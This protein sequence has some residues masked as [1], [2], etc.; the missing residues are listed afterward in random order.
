VTDYHSQRQ[1]LAHGQ[2][3]AG[4]P[5]F[6]GARLERAAESNIPRLNR[7]RPL[8]GCE[9]PRAI[10]RNAHRRS[11]RSPA[12][13]LFPPVGPQTSRPSQCR[14]HARAP[15]PP[16]PPVQRL[17]N[18]TF[19]HFLALL[20]GSPEAYLFLRKRVSSMMAA[21]R[22]HFLALCPRAATKRAGLHL[23]AGVCFEPAQHRS[24]HKDDRGAFDRAKQ[25]GSR[26]RLS[27]ANCAAYPYYNI[28]RF[29]KIINAPMA[30][31]RRI[32]IGNIAR[33]RH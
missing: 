28:R 23:I 24:G 21:F 3:V 22:C 26:L 13:G 20:A 29:T 14:N 9:R 27:L 2:A 31:W 6:P 15:T 19:W 16:Q 7:F 1:S 18:G 12:P 10:A 5:R 4:F 33:V 11:V 25:Q 32:R 30:V 8:P 17:K